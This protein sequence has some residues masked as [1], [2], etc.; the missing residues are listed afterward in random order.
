M[1]DFNAKVGKEAQTTTKGKFGLEEKNKIGAK[2]LK[3]DARINLKIANNFFQKNVR[4]NGM[5][6]DLTR[7]ENKK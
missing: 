4:G 1:G 7:Q 2:L 5:D 6:R 3:I